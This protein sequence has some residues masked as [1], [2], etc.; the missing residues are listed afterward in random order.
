MTEKQNL[1]NW[2]KSYGKAMA[3][4]DPLLI[5]F[6]TMTVQNLLNTLPDNWTKKEEPKPESI[7]ETNPT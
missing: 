3:S 7:E 2:V 5:N 6:S 1:I 4:G